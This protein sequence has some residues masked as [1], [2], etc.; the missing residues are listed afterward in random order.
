MDVDFSEVQLMPAMA[1]L[2][3]VGVG[4]L[5]PALLLVLARLFRNSARRL[6]A[7][8]LAIVAALMF[9][10]CGTIF[11]FYG[12]MRTE[13]TGFEVRVR[14]GWLTSYSATI[15]LGEIQSAEV[16]RYNAVDE[17]GGW[18]IRGTENN[19]VLSQSGDLGV[20]LQLAKGRKILIGS[21]RPEALAKAIN[22]AREQAD[23]G[24]RKE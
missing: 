11:V 20:Q 15:P 22:D 24:E 2:I 19:R 1:W 23:L 16:I 13:V 14:F 6:S 17:F 9:L 21:S 7:P 10:L 8:L 12:I 4:V 3:L 18:G 5:L